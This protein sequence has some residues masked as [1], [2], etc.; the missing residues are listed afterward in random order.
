M[1]ALFSTW[2][3]AVYVLILGSFSS[4]NTILDLFEFSRSDV[5]RYIAIWFYSY[6][7][8]FSPE[9]FLTL[10]FVYLYKNSIY[11]F[12]EWTFKNACLGQHIKTRNEL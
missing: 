7:K 4:F 11:V 6:Y 8:Y 1:K 9:L 10:R 12:P 5:E 2:T 3:S